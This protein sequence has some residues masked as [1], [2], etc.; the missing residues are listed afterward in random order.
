MLENTLVGTFAA[1]KATVPKLIKDMSSFIF[2]CLL[3][4]PKIIIKVNK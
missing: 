2:F 3:P 1:L 4:K